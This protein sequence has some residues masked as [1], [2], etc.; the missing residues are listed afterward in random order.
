MIVKNESQNLTRC[1][2]SLAKLRENVSNE[3]IIV[4]T[5]ST[6][7]TKEIAA[8]YKAEVRDFEWRDDFAAARNESL[9]G[10]KGEWFMF[11]DADEAFIDTQ[12]LIDFFLSP[13]SK[14]YGGA[15]YYQRNFIGDGVYNDFPVCRIAKNFNGLKFTD[16]VHEYL[17]IHGTVFLIEAF[18]E[19]YSYIGETGKNRSERNLKL[20]E[21][22]LKRDPK[23]PMIYLHI[24]Q[25]IYNEDK[26]KFVSYLQQGLKYCKPDNKI[27]P[28]FYALII[29][30]S[31]AQNDTKTVLATYDL[32]RKANIKL[33]REN[34]F[35][36]A[37]IDIFGL[38]GLTLSK[39]KKY[40]EAARLLR[41]YVK[42]VA[43]Y[44][45]GGLRTPDV[46]INSPLMISN[47]PNYYVIIREYAKALCETG[48][49]KAA[50]RIYRQWR[51]NKYPNWDETLLTIGMI[52]KNE[53][54]TLEKCLSSLNSLRKNVKCELII[55]DTGSED[56]TVAIAEKYADE[57]RHFKWIND[58]SA[59]R[60]ESMRDGKG[61]WFMF[62]DGDEWFES[63]A[64]IEEFFNSGEYVYYNF[65][66]YFQRNYIRNGQND[67]R[68]PRMTRLTP[69][70]CFFKT[71]HESLHLLTPVKYF[72]DYVHHY[73][74]YGGT[75]TKKNSRNI[76][77]LLDEIK[78]N[79][80]DP[81]II[82]QLAV[83]Y[84]GNDD[85]TMLKWLQKGY[86]VCMARGNDWM[87]ETFVNTMAKHY[88]AYHQY[89]KCYE[90][91]KDLA[92]ARVKIEQGFAYDIDCV[93]YWGFT[94]HAL[95]KLQE[96][97]EAYE[98][99]ILLYRLYLDGKLDSVQVMI[100]TPINISPERFS[101]AMDD[102][103][104]TLI[105]LGDWE[106][107]MGAAEQSPPA[108]PEDGE[109]KLQMR[110][111][112]RILIMRKLGNYNRIDVFIKEFITP[113]MPE[114]IKDYLFAAL[115]NNVAEIDNPIDCIDSVI[116]AYRRLG[117]AYIPPDYALLFV[118]LHNR[119][120]GEVMTAENV[121]NLVSQTKK[122]SLLSADIVP[123]LMLLGLSVDLISEKTAPEDME[124][125]YSSIYIFKENFDKIFVD[126]CESGI[127]ENLSA[128]SQLFILKIGVSILID[129]DNRGF[130]TC[131]AAAQELLFVCD[132]Y[133][134]KV[135]PV[136]ITTEENAEHIP[137]TVRAVYFLLMSFLHRQ[138]KN[139]TEHLRMLRLALKAEPGLKNFIAHEMEKSKVYR[140]L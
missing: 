99:Y 137:P 54:K 71:I 118:M 3:L 16:I 125:F 47:N 52:V 84:N 70:Q 24:A 65:G 113:E 135:F 20:L 17:N 29:T 85:E 5:G 33:K 112:Q 104:D 109:K 119:E 126:Y 60:N 21:K 41:D 48:D 90:L 43:R 121:E 129:F 56:G 30:A 32:Y 94:C 2:E 22:Q 1:L 72:T 98:R 88:L 38:T 14:K 19:H 133:L 10:A 36:A 6:D 81:I 28:V 91:L 77:Y 37:E 73:G 103:T 93:C 67:F 95:G 15:S 115:R 18:A 139:I 55:V 57:I 49:Y 35:L 23:N 76:N 132:K 79:P 11:I 102:F 61:D 45:E 130:D 66:T 96:A 13:D 106:A 92:P 128:R 122:I 7:N 114:N 8:Q 101:A 62:I 100:D 124:R 131:D 86:D 140:W 9:R 120:I 39:A 46:L 64:Q 134:E 127:L 82:K 53:A 87:A 69:E 97:R 44:E 74:Y 31:A 40:K 116:I 78:K 12:P 63:T 4:D 75:S 111:L 123:L 117:T 26:Q 68:A 83:S 42:M 59:A 50:D 80:D 136:E 34:G 27:T 107:A 58:F 51:H 89:D 25:S 108:T 110:I 105:K 138:N